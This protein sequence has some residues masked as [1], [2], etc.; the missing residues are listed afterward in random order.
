MQIFNFGLRARLY[1]GFGVLVVLGLGMAGFA[2]S[3]LS[4]VA[5]SVDSMVATSSNLVRVLEVSRDI[6][7]LRRGTARY[8]VEADPNA[9]K[10]MKEAEV[11]VAGLLAEAAN[12]TASDQRRKLYNGIGDTLRAAA[13]ERDAFVRLFQTGFAERAKLA[14]A[15]DVL[16]AATTRLVVATGQAGADADQSAAAAHVNASVLLVSV[17]SWRFLATL[18]PKGLAAFKANLETAKVA[19]GDLDAIA[20][21]GIKPLI[22]PVRDALSAYAASFELTSA[23]LI[24][25]AGHIDNQLRPRFIAM[26][27][28]A[29]AAVASL[30]EAFKANAADSRVAAGRTMWIQAL[31][32]GAAALIGALLAYMTGRGIVGPIASMTSAM[33]RLAKGDLDID[34][35]ARENTDEVGAMAHAVEVFKQNAIDN[36][37]M[38]EANAK[39]HAARDLRQ[40]AMDNH[41]QDFGTS[42]SGVMVSLGASAKAMHAAANDMSEAAKRTRDTTSGAVEGANSSAR[43][44]NSVAVAAEQMAASIKE[45]SRQVAHVT[46]AV[47]KA[48]DRAAETDKKVAGL[49]DTADRIGDVVR[50][51][52][53]I[54]GQTNLL[55][56]NATIEAARAGEAGKGFA[57]VAS[58]VKTLAT[59]TARATDQIGAQI[60]AIRGSTGEAVQAVREVGLAIGQVVEIAAAIAAAV[61]QQAIATQ[62][63]SS[64]VQNV[65]QATNN[66]AHAMEQVLGIAE[67]TDTASGTV[68]S[69]ANEVGRTADTLSAE[70][71]GFLTAMKRVGMAGEPMSEFQ[72]AA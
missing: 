49:A 45:I 40:V 63:I 58:E 53:D 8:R 41:T 7:A 29:D 23:S 14:T 1:L 20:G 17:A 34:V 24:D 61:E 30:E 5:G 28:D 35:P 44:L 21:D 39:A 72:A 59:Q 68:L 51:I 3:G 11:Q 12:E 25:G 66:A 16:S 67:Q 69:A 6:E 22:G 55:A 19:L 52:T 54:A 37:R 38:T 32:S 36:R 33:T 71:N 50:L 4:N 57:V 62:E 18:D 48:V 26:Q 56:L 31:V 65:T 9:L 2:M 13:V 42:V 64:S 47:A 27:M 10:D 43:D 70:V 46:T 15:G 60:V